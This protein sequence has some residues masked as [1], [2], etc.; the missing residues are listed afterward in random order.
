MS[1][2]DRKSLAWTCR[3]LFSL[4]NS[5]AP[6]LTLKLK[7]EGFLNLVRLHR[8]SR[9]LLSAGEVHWQGSQKQSRR[10]RS[11]NPLTVVGH[12][13]RFM[14]SILSTS[15]TLRSL[16]LFR[17]EVSPSHQMA[18]VSIPTLRDLTLQES[19]FVPTNE[20]MPPT[21]ITSLSLKQGV[22]LEAPMRHILNLLAGSL[23]TLALDTT[24]LSIRPF[25]DSIQLAHLAHFRDMGTGWRAS[26]MAK[27]TFQS[28]I[29]TLF[30]GPTATHQLATIPP[31]ILPQLREL[32]APCDVGKQI[33]PGRPV[34]YFR[35]TALKEVQMGEIDETLSHFSQSTAGITNLEMCTQLTVPSLFATLERRV[36]RIERFRLL[37]ESDKFRHNPNFTATNKNVPRTG[38]AA[39]TE[40]EIRFRAYAGC[41][42]PP[43]ISTSNCQTIF[44]ALDR[45]CP[46]LNVVTFT[47]VGAS[48]RFEKDA[49][50]L[51]PQSV[52]KLCKTGAGA[53]EK[54]QWGTSINTRD[55]P[56]E[57]SPR[58]V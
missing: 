38:A 32:S 46:V 17:V 28:T 57:C 23:H 4:L 58:R 41:H 8:Y 11:A 50:D 35:D 33:I 49:S 45:A 1:P 16:R 27:F 39:L 48:E 51:P 56:H 53:W 44:E 54:Q 24:Q 42:N 47:V 12:A 6:F 10:K 5:K 20:K 21:S 15:T 37:T 7:A 36:P 26:D 52:Y 19:L 29:T 9:V 3:T 18:I 2:S 14:F 22:H 34:T 13:S 40:V 43:F 31:G 25:L 30:L 55:N